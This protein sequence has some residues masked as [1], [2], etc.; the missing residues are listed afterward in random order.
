MSVVAFGAINILK[1]AIHSHGISNVNKSGNLS[2]VKQAIARIPSGLTCTLQFTSGC[3]V[4]M[5]T[6][7]VGNSSFTKRLYSSCTNCGLNQ[8]S[9]T[10]DKACYF[11]ANP[12]K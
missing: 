1:R 5:Q 2:E 10:R 3:K 6:F 12:S 8:S 4:R 11:T 7:K 9:Y